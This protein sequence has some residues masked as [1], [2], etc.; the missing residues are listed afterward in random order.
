[1]NLDAVTI[2]RKKVNA[3]IAQDWG[4]LSDII[5]LFMIESERRMRFIRLTRDVDEKIVLINPLQIR[6]VYEYFDKGSTVVDYYGSD[7]G[8][9]Y[10][11]VRESVE[12]IEKMVE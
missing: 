10:I 5:V 11:E 12:T 2:V 3:S 7:E 4:S 9:G 8:Y 6:A 1:M